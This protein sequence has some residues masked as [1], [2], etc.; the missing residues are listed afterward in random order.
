[1]TIEDKHSGWLTVRVFSKTSM[2]LSQRKASVFH[3]LK[4]CELRQ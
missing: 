4:G 1:M 3:R 2:S